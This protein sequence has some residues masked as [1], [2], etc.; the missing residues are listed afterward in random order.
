[1]T[2]SSF[3]RMRLLLLVLVLSVSGCGQQDVDSLLRLSGAATYDG[4]PIPFGTVLFNPDTSLQHS[5]PQGSASIENGR[6]R[7]ASGTPGVKPGPHIVTVNGYAERPPIVEG[8][9]TTADP[10]PSQKPLFPTFIVKLDLTSERQD[11]HVPLQEPAPKS[12]R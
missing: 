7:I 12:S 3:S 1:M 11:I 8:D 5:G 2:A 10:V 6:Y 9:P 4:K